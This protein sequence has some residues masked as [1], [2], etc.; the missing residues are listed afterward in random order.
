M[1]HDEMRKA[2]SALRVRIPVDAADAAALRA[3]VRA[4]DAAFAAGTP[5]PSQRTDG[6]GRL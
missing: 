3:E 2:L 4:V 1:D 6:E 5:T